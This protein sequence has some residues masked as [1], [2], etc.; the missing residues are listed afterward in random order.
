M[1][2]NKNIM[3]LINIMDLPPTMLRATLYTN[4]FVGNI[5]VARDI[6]AHSIVS[7]N[8]NANNINISAGVGGNLTANNFVGNFVGNVIAANVV[9]DSVT[10]SGNIRGAL[11][12]I[13]NLATGQINVSGNVVLSPGKSVFASQMPFFW[14][15][16]I[17]GNPATGANLIY[18]GAIAD[19]ATY[20]DAQL[21]VRLTRAVN[22]VSG[23]IKWNVTGFDFTK[24]FTMRS[25]IY[26]G[27]GADGIWMGVG[28][29]D[30]GGG[31]NYGTPN[32]GRAMRLWSYTYNYTEFIGG[33]GIRIGQLQNNYSNLQ[34]IW[35]TA[36]LTVR[37]I[38]N[39]RYMHVFAKNEL[40]HAIDITGW[41]PGG[42]YIYIGASTGGAN[43]LHYCSH[44]E[45]KYI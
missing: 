35:V 42:N 45:L 32:G 20:I 27:S 39:R 28:A 1:F 12:N 44:V 25:F 43:A 6:T 16:P 24:D 13:G 21:G 5:N 33:D 14:T 31:I 38:G 15:A 10:V 40:Q 8:V 4:N 3:I 37:T 26:M 36:D 17:H 19:D 7:G 41:V 23:S 11:A 34:A 29:S 30:P 9:S 18:T 2:I 22:A